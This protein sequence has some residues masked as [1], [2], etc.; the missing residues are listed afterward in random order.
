MWLF[1]SFIFYFLPLILWLFIAF[2]FK[3]LMR[4]KDILSK[5][6]SEFSF[7]FSKVVYLGWWKRKYLACW[8][9]F[10]SMKPLLTFLCCF[11]NW[12]GWEKYA[13]NQPYLTFTIDNKLMIFVIIQNIDSPC[14]KKSLAIENA[15]SL[16]L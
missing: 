4:E 11:M 5:Y 15:K 14:L 8:P 3:R 16:Q 13:Y 10:L 2:F 6:I 9:F 7:I 12:N 1:F